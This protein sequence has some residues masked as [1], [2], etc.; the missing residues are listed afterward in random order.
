MHWT[1]VSQL[2]QLLDSHRSG[3]GD[4]VSE[5][6]G[7]RGEQDLEQ[8]HEQ[9]HE[10]DQEST[11]EVESVYDDDN[12]SYDSISGSEDE[13]SGVS[14]PKKK[15]TVT[16][17]EREQQVR[18]HTQR[19]FN[20]EFYQENAQKLWD[21]TSASTKKFITKVQAEMPE[22]PESTKEA[23]QRFSNLGVAHKALFIKVLMFACMMI[24]MMGLIIGRDVEKEVE[25]IDK[26][27]ES[28]DYHYLRGS[29]DNQNLRPSGDHYS[30]W[31]KPQTLAPW[32]EPEEEEEEE[33]KTGEDTH[34]ENDPL[35]PGWKE[36]TDPKSGDKYYADPEGNTTWDRPKSTPTLPEGWKE[37]SDKKTGKKYYYSSQTGETTWEWPTQAVTVLAESTRTSTSPD[38]DLPPGWKKYVDADTGKTYFANEDG[39]TTWDRPTMEDSH[40]SDDK[41]DTIAEKLEKEAKPLPEGWVEKIDPSSGRPYYK[42]PTGEKQWQRPTDEDEAES[43]SSSSDSYSAS[44]SKSEDESLPPGWIQKTNPKTG[45]IYYY[46]EK[47]KA[48]SNKVPVDHSDDAASGSDSSSNDSEDLKNFGER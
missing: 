2:N 43:Q 46:N 5:E 38:G 30:P 17:Q 41:E 45:K 26:E 37:Y 33:E 12:Y 40:E 48:T 16:Q 32:E 22:L 47:T 7:I 36:Y 18:L 4:D 6:Y 14:K 23:Y 10:Q 25:I 21:T 42:G 3:H 27:I 29:S 13:W 15:R 44:S 8:E 35:P 39:E 20:A 31:D 24:M 28:S 11:T 9:D 34:N 19:A 1:S